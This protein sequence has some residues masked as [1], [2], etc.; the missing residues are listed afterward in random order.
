MITPEIILGP[1][2]T[3]KTTTLLGMV[4]DELANGVEPSR[5]G[6]LSFTRRAAEEAVSR[7]C[8]KFDGM[9]KSDF[10]YFRTLHSLCFKVMGLS[11]SGILEGKRLEEFGRLVGHKI[12]GR[13]SLED[14]TVFG[15][16]KGD[17]LLFM[18]NLARVRGV[19]LREA[20]DEDSDELSFHEVRRFSDALAQ[21]KRDTGTID[22]TDMLVEFVNSDITVDLDVLFVDE[23][24]DLSLLQWMVVWKLAATVRRFVIAGDDDQAIYRWAGADVDTLVN[25]PGD[26]RVLSQSWRV[27]REVQKVAS[28]IVS[29]IRT[30]REKIWRPRED[31]GS[32]RWHPSLE[33][34]DLSGPDI[35]VLGR[36]R[37]ILREFENSIRSLGYLYEF[38]GARSI[39]PS[40]LD[41]VLTWERIRKGRSGVTLADCRKMYDLMTAKKSIRHGHKS[42]PG[43]HDDEEVTYEILVE[44]GG[45]IVDRE[46]LWFDALD[47]MSLVDISYIRAALRRKEDLLSPPRIRLSTIHGIK[48]GEAKEVILLTDMA[49]RTLQ[50]AKR[51]PDDECRVWYVA[52]TRAREKLHIVAPQ[53]TRY[54]HI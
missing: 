53:T 49:A 1:P 16:E 43:V 39:R 50:E 11:S 48:G 7:A 27:P 9:R 24:Q 19:L 37:Y 18:E 28:E 12:T 13:F 2:G 46:K 42:L 32:V 35:L 47:K 41:G 3:G 21:Y 5:I 52:V 44:R 29:R 54:F 30:R 45:L 40:V 20:Y 33:S 17:R 8:E 15:F 26:V 6:Y 36:N 4:Q 38:Q 14:G 22:F 31:D 10:P 23:A 34:V 25:M 51:N